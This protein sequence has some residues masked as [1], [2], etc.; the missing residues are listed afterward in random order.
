MF[1]CNKTLKAQ[2]KSE[3]LIRSSSNNCMLL[4]TSPDAAPFC[5]TWFKVTGARNDGRLDD[6][7][8]KTCTKMPSFQITS[9]GV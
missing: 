5:N 6:R 9:T 4:F 7:L 3:W 8:K 2:H 1:L